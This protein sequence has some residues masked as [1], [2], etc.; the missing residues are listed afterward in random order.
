MDASVKLLILSALVFSF[1]VLLSRI[2][3]SAGAPAGKAMK[4]RNEYVARRKLL[5]DAWEHKGEFRGWF[6]FL[7]VL[8]GLYL[9]NHFYHSLVSTGR[10]FSLGGRGYLMTVFILEF[11]EFLAVITAEYLACFA[12]YLA[13]RLILRGHRWAAWA[14]FFWICGMLAVTCGYVF[15]RYTALS[16]S[17]RFAA[18][19]Q[20][21]VLCMKMH[22]YLRANARLAELVGLGKR[23][24]KDLLDGLEGEA[25]AEVRERQEFRATVYPRNLTL[26]N[27]VEFT[28]LPV[29][30]YEPKYPRSASRSFPYVLR[31]VAE[32]LVYLVCVW[33]LLEFRVNPILIG[34]A[35]PL[36][37]VLGL[38]APVALVFVLLFLIVFDC[39]LPGMAE[40]TFFADREFYGD[41][42][43]CT[44]FEEFSRKWNKP[45]H[46]FLLRHVLVDAHVHWGLS[47]KLAGVVTFL[48]SI[49]LHEILVTAV[50]SRFTPYLAFF[51]LFQ[52]PFLSVMRS[53]IFKGQWFGNV[54]FWTSL[55]LGLSLIVS[56]YF[57]EYCADANNCLIG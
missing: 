20:C 6:T 32:I 29:L 57:K 17:F 14:H 26:A 42:W 52:I 45:V 47:R 51:S 33:L 56:L 27:F 1:I 18:I 40:L 48:V 55:I 38:M 3:P 19:A 53:P 15:R 8:A 39:I 49:V 12:A 5:K 54:T 30:V 50:L 22:S 7:A 41:W 37:A 13:Q 31:K 28:F 25:L 9:I 44:T 43:N 4:T 16:I 11:P 23:D 35:D 2:F 36:E 46:E 10:L 34:Q 21:L 24:S